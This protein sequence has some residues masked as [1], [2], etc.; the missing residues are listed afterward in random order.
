MR[1]QYLISGLASLAMALPQP[2]H[3][4]RHL[5]SLVTSRTEL[6][7]TDEVAVEE[8]FQAA[9]KGMSTVRRTLTVTRHANKS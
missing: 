9:V 4:T 6:N 1:S 8:A 3:S 7:L 2:Q 5:P